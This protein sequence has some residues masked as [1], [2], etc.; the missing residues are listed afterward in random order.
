MMETVLTV[1]IILGA[2]THDSLTHT[3]YRLTPKNTVIFSKSHCTHKTP[4]MEAADI[5]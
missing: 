4:F 1:W 3:H 2:V 5:T